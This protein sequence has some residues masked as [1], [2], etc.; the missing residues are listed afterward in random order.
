VMKNASDRE[1]DAI[2]RIRQAGE[3]YVQFGLTYPD[4][5][6]LVFMEQRPHAPV[7][8]AIVEHGNVDQDPYA[9]AHSLFVALAATGT[10]RNDELSTHMM[11]QIFWQGLHGMTSIAIV[12]GEGDDWTPKIDPHLYL[13]ALLDVLMIGILQRFAP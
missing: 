8:A 1:V 9:F 6:A 12:M 5:Y 13:K 2:N 10:V 3:A 4:E 11:T 7:E